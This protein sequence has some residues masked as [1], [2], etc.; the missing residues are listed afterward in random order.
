MSI[1]GVENYRWCGQDRW[2]RSKIATGAAI[3]N[4]LGDFTLAPEFTQQIMIG[5][6]QSLM[7]GRL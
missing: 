3:A 6:E 5:F 4:V 2:G 1:P 7:Q